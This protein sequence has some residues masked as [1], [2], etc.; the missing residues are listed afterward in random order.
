MLSQVAHIL[1]SCYVPWICCAFTKCVN[2]TSIIEHFRLYSGK[3]HWQGDRKSLKNLPICW[4]ILLFP[5]SSAFL[6]CFSYNNLQIGFGFV[7]SLIWELFLLIKQF[8]L[9]TFFITTGLFEFNL[10]MVFG[11]SC[12][13][14]FSIFAQ[15]P[16]ECQHPYSCLF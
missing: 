7:L 14:A 3:G 1:D 16:T 6:Y 12:F 11:F 8:S 9:F 13:P 5:L 15:P 4:D 10:N 2:T